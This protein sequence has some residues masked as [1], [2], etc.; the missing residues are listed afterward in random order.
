MQEQMEQM[1]KILLPITVLCLG[2]VF[3]AVAATKVDSNPSKQ[4]PWGPV[5]AGKAVA[6]VNGQPVEVEDV[7]AHLRPPEPW[8]GVEPPT[9]P[10][11]LALDEAL[12]VELFAQEA[13]RRSIEVPEGPP[14][15]VEA[16]FVQGLINR[17]LENTEGVEP[18][19]ISEAEARRYYEGNR[20][21]STAPGR[22]YLSAVVVDSSEEA[23]RL[24][25]KAEDESD[26]AFARLAWEHSLHEP[27]RASGGRLTVLNADKPDDEVEDAISGVGYS[28]VEAGQVGL[29]RV[30]DG[31]YYVLRA[32]SLE[33][34][35]KPWDEK[36]ALLT[37]NIV[38]EE[39]QEQILA[40]LEEGLHDNA[41]VEVNEA[42]LHK[43][44]APTWEEYF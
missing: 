40:N 32:T 3:V 36:T 17:E 19:N 12:R 2:I 31:Q 5:P 39:R 25:R 43:L 18:D 26:R 21:I 38:A 11:Q 7:V 42:D 1:I 41:E 8:V 44:R 29:A 33:R 30:S 10:R 6:R 13:E 9:D 27:S 20:G 23:R 24:L 37:K 16:G 35:Q 22:V 28:M 14:A 15:V 4:Y 34:K